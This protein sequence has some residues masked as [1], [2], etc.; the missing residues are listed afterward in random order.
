MCVWC[1]AGRA[2]HL[3][4]VDVHH[5]RGGSTGLDHR[6]IERGNGNVEGKL[7]RRDT[8]ARPHAVN[9]ARGGSG[10]AWKA[11]EGR[12]AMVKGCVRRSRR[13][14][15]SKSEA[16]FQLK[17]SVAQHLFVSFLLLNARAKS[18]SQTWCASHRKFHAAPLCS[19]FSTNFFRRREAGSREWDVS[20]RAWRRTPRHQS[21]FHVPRP[22]SQYEVLQQTVAHQSCRLW[23]WRQQVSSENCHH[24]PR[25]KKIRTPLPGTQCCATIR[26]SASSACWMVTVL[27]ATK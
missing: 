1:R 21:S 22:T 12:L 17:R 7:R 3:E 24:H 16:P 20:S 11:E 15:C 2:S 14:I 4:A 26:T 23:A 27:L 10:A 8:T 18:D 5:L 25:P 19:D 6:R 13:S 9:N